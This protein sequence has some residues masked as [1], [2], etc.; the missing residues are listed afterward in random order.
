M[1]DRHVVRV[2]SG[3]A[4]LA[5]ALTLGACATGSSDSAGAIAPDVAA[6]EAFSA[7]DQSVERAETATVATEP[8]LIKQAQVDMTVEDITSAAAELRA[9]AASSGG[10]VTY[11]TIQQSDGATYPSSM[12][13]SVPADKLDATVDQVAAVGTVISRSASSQD[14]SAQYVD[15][16][17]RIESLQRSVDRLRTLIDEATSVTD[18]AA[19]ESELTQREADL[20]S[21]KAQMQ[22]LQGSV[23]QST[24]NVTMSTRPEVFEDQ[25]G[26][27]LSG[28]RAG[29]R[30]FLASVGILLTALGALL[31][32]AVAGAVVLVPLF[33]V[34]RRRFRSRPAGHPVV[35]GPGGMPSAGVS[36][37]AVSAPAVT[38]PVAGAPAV[39]AP[40]TGAPQAGPQTPPAT[41][42]PSAPLR[43]ERH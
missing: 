29:W 24:I 19:I 15:T 36:A 23:E 39:T 34:L 21:L 2:L 5:L 31:P 3:S 11:E 25:S 27:F 38:A 22:S 26:G 20:D 8:K 41:E 42:P 10:A 16:Q 32:F 12:T 14:V 28:L 13:L 18:I 37:P 7:A 35:T 6:G 17:A 40:A 9:I 33:L 1:T 43:D 30:A 4:A